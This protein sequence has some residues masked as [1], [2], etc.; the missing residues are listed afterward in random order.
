MPLSAWGVL[1]LSMMY[2]SAAP[3]V[4][5]VAPGPIGNGNELIIFLSIARSSASPAEWRR[6]AEAAAQWFIS[7]TA[8]IAVGFAGQTPNGSPETEMG[9]DSYSEGLC[10]R[11]E[12]S[13]QQ[14][15]GVVAPVPGD[16]RV[17]LVAARIADVPHLRDDAEAAR[18]DRVEDLADGRLHL[19]N[20]HVVQL[21]EKR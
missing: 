21:H 18:I 15:F 5:T 13:V 11:V 4:S 19:P 2:C 16:F 10:G 14:I 6:C 12:N 1:G 20:D 9:E 8:P 3:P 7:V 17:P